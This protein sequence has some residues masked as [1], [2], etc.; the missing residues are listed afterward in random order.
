M[1][2]NSIVRIAGVFVWAGIFHVSATDAATETV[3]YTFQ[4]GADSRVPSPGLK[5]TVT[6]AAFSR[7]NGVGIV[8]AGTVFLGRNSRHRIQT[9]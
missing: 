2:P 4:G 5:I 3:V 7:D 8:A 6:T 9:G 1:K